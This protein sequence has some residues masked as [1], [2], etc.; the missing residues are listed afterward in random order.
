MELFFLWKSSHFKFPSLWDY[1]L[2]PSLSSYAENYF[3]CHS[4]PI[5][6][7]AIVGPISWFAIAGPI[8][9]R[10]HCESIYIFARAIG[11]VVLGRKRIYVIPDSENWFRCEY[12]D[13]YTL[14]KALEKSSM[15]QLYTA[16]PREIFKTNPIIIYQLLVSKWDI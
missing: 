16:I 4:R 12:S 1:F 15:F 6:W 11:T 5:F 13:A 2:T 8:S 9:L 10:V 3:I 14:Q 7:F